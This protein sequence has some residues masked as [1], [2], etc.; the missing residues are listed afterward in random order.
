[1]NAP[2]DNGRTALME[3]AVVGNGE[4]ERLLQNAKPRVAAQV[5]RGMVS[6][7]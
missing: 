4:I 7:D 1:V 5:T 3:A 2:G 6:A